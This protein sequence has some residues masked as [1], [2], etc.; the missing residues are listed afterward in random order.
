MAIINN[1]EHLK[2]DKAFTDKHN[3]IF[4]HLDLHN[5]DLELSHDFVPFKSLI[6][7]LSKDEYPYNYDG[8]FDIE[9]ESIDGFNMVL[10]QDG[11]SVATYAAKRWDAIDTSYGYTEHFKCTD[12]V[13][14]PDGLADV[15]SFYSSCQWVSKA[16]RGK[17]LGIVLDHLKKHI[18]FDIFNADAQYSMHTEDLRDYHI[19]AL[20]YT[21]SQ[22]LLT[23]PGGKVYN[24]A[25]VSKED[26]N[27]KDE[28]TYTS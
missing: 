9:M 5:L 1:H 22:K 10:K 12:T 7:S 28:E 8:T 11:I 15:R 21:D 24:I 6:E 18:C 16:H 23:I 13:P 19:N 4:K 3:I 25:W 2:I 26:W 20:G 27:D 14:I 17:K